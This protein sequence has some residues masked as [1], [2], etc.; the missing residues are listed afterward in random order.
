MVFFLFV[1]R[2]IE[3]KKTFISGC[4]DRAVVRVAREMG[5]GPKQGMYFRNYFV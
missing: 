5:E 1:D 4:L 2:F 3:K